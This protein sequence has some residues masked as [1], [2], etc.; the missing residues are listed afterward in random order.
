MINNHQIKKSNLTDYINGLD[1]KVKSSLLGAA[2]GGLAGSVIGSTSAALVPSKYDITHSDF[3]LDGTVSKRRK[4][5]EK[6]KRAPISQ[7]IRSGL[8]GLLVGASRPWVEDPIKEWLQP[9]LSKGNL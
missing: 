1:P 9:K 5:K 6:F 7:G 4:Y 8:I 3:K 2:T